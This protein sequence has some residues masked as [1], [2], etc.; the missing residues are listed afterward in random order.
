MREPNLYIVA[1]PKVVAPSPR[2]RELI[3]SCELLNTVAEKVDQSRNANSDN[4]DPEFL[5]AK[6]VT[7]PS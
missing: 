3:L 6:H 4:R 2:L 1:T 5:P 7:L